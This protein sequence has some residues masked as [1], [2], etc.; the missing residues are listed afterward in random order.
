MAKAAKA[1]ANYRYGTAS[2][3]CSLCSMF[4]PPHSCTAVLGEISPSALCDYFER[5]S[6]EQSRNWYGK[7]K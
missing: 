7:E 3:K 5:K 1:K 2:R 4:R 6:E